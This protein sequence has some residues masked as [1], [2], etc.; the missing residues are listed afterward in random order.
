MGGCLPEAYGPWHGTLILIFLLWPSAWPGCKPAGAGDVEEAS[1]SLRQPLLSASCV[2]VFGAGISV[3]PWLSWSRGCPCRTRPPLPPPPLPLVQLSPACSHSWLDGCPHIQ[4]TSD[5]HMHTCT[6]ALIHIWAYHFV[7][8]LPCVCVCE[9]AILWF[10]VSFTL[11]WCFLPLFVFKAEMCKMNTTS[12]P[13]SHK[14]I[15]YFLTFPQSH[16][17]ARVVV[18]LYLSFEKYNSSVSTQKPCHADQGNPANL[19]HSRCCL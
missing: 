1:V 12:S 3:R 19:F 18:I 7:F 15:T 5:T 13:K 14:Q 4:L 8:N 11:H 16:A 9:C 17:A 6:H 10:S 2:S